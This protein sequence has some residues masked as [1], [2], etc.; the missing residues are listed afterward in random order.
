MKRKLSV[1]VLVIV[2]AMAFMPAGAFGETKASS[3]DVSVIFTSDM[4]S[5]MQAG[6]GT[7]GL[8]RVKTFVD[9]VKKE[10]PDSLL[11]DGGDFSMGTPYQTIFM[12]DASELKI[13]G[14]LGYDATTLGNHEFDYK[15][16][17]LASMLRTAA[18]YKKSQHMPYIVSGNINWK[19]SL[20]S[21]SLGKDA[22]SLKKAMDNYG[23]S[24]YRIIR[25]NG[26]RIAV[27]GIMGKESI[28]DAPQS[29]L[30][31]NDRIGRA[32][33][34]V[35]KI[36][37]EGDADMIVCLSHSGIYKS[38][39]DKAED[40]V[41]A[42]EVPAIDLILSGHS[43]EKMEKPLK[44]GHTTIVSCGCFTDYAG[45]V[46]LTRSGSRYKVKSYELKKLD[47]SVAENSKIKADVDSFQSKI[48]SEYFSKFGYTGSQILAKSK[49]QFS[50][51]GVLDT[52]VGENP[53]GNL[54][55]DSYIYAFDKAE[56]N[57]GDPV[58]VAVVPSGVIRGSID[59]GS[60]TVTDAFNMA[61]LGIG[62]DNVPGYPLV[63]IYATG[64]EIKLLAEV[65]VSLSPMMSGTKLYFSGLKYKYNSHRLILN[66]TYDVR[67]KDSNGK[68]VKIHNNKLYHVVVDMYS[69][70]MIGAIKNK[71]KGLLSFVP[72]DK[73]GNQIKDLNKAVITGDRGEVKMWYAVAS[74]IDSFKK[75]QVPAKYGSDQGRKINET[76]WNPVSLLKQPNKVAAV[77]T[78]LIVVLILLIAGI[79]M[80][81][82]KLRR[83]R[84]KTA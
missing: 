56:G 15:A 32:K 50:D 60:I 77:V 76:G 6:K 9:R 72:K 59:K 49:Y 45:H 83:R 29:G 20:A 81:I 21:A 64:S 84:K 66:R 17:G 10:Y 3:K 13:M 69:C 8:A 1:V 34:I 55:S 44:E 78:L 42:K 61:S 12:S 5:H 75:D 43:H 73:N 63:S 11:V 51:E 82:R 57:T 18:K 33:A 36:K 16:G 26:V 14:E 52:V 67:I 27:F 74:Y 53:L 37:A 39:G 80:F 35:K 2:L 47:E 68:Y 23:V 31:W 48:N 22:A 65:D 46:V 28:A 58:N 70:Q 41:L 38:Q 4:H 25:K 40:I 19:K 62:P 7:G 79:I 71:S 54:L 24:D 30:S